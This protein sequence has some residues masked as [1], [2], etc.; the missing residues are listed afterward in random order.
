MTDLLNQSQTS[1]SKKPEDAPSA[2]ILVNPLWAGKNCFSS[3]SHFVRTF[4]LETLF[5]ITQLA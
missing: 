1:D 4:S 2:R 5:F 3:Y